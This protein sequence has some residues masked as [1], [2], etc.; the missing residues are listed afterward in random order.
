MAS[1]ASIILPRYVADRAREIEFRHDKG[2]AST[3]EP[4]RYLEPL[5]S[6]NGRDSPLDQP[7]ATEHR[8]F[9]NLRV[10][11]GRLP[12]RRSWCITEKHG[13]VLKRSYSNSLCDAG[14]CL[15]RT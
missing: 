11:T 7:L 6:G 2:V 4:D 3:A 12:Q 14:A 15:I 10:Q 1:R 5:A 9:A 13:R 8:Q